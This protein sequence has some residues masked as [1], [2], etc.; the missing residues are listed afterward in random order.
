MFG[1]YGRILKERA[2]GRRLTVEGSKFYIL[3]IERSNALLQTLQALFEGHLACL[4]H[5]NLASYTLDDLPNFLL[6]LAPKIGE[7]CAN[8]NHLWVLRT[9]FR[10][11]LGHLSDHRRFARP[12]D[13]YERRREHSAS[14]FDAVS[15]LEE[16]LYLSELSLRFRSLGSGRDDLVRQFRNLRSCG[17]EVVL[18]LDQSVLAAVRFDG[19][20]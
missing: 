7:F 5:T 8:G 18:A 6:Y 10:T 15:G 9:K 4:R 3:F 11:E 20:L 13:L 17:R 14:R 12:Q 16:A 19:P 1:K 2:V